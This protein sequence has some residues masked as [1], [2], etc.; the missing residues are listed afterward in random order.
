MYIEKVGEH[1]DDLL[2][3][4]PQQIYQVVGDAIP[5]HDPHPDYED[6]VGQARMRYYLSIRRN[7]KLCGKACKL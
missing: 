3:T 4:H 6:H 5:E 2:A 1:T 7:E